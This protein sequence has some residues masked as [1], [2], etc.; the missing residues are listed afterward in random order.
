M[1]VRQEYGT[2]KQDEAQ[3]VLQG[4]RLIQAGVAL[5]LFVSLQG[6]VLGSFASPALGRSVH[7]LSALTGVML[8]ALGL[9]WPRL[10]LG[11]VALGLAFWFLLYSN[12]AT[13]AAFAL[14][15]IWG[16][17]NSIIPLAAGSA[18]GS[19]FQEAVIS[20]ILYTA[21]PTGS[22]SSALIVWGLRSAPAKG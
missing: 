11:V 14:A 19:D 12:L 18:H 10:R 4:H 16:A 22:I 17:G 7:T 9:A 20:V 5:F 15:A 6:L 1:N 8:A 3:L 21:A 13:I 2:S